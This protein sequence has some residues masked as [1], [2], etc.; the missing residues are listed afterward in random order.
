ME[1]DRKMQRENTCAGFSFCNG[2]YIFIKSQGVFV[3][4]VPSV[5]SNW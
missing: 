1:E 5:L 4:L 2:M 3:G